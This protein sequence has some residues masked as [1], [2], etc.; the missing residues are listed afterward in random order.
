MS[1]RKRRSPVGA[2]RPSAGRTPRRPSAVDLSAA[3]GLTDLEVLRRGVGLLP[4]AGDPDPGYA[5]IVLG[6]DGERSHVRGCTCKVSRQRTC[7]H[8]L[9]LG[10][11]LREA[12]RRWGSLDWEAAFAGTL[13]ARLAQLLF[14]GE[15]GRRITV[16]VRPRA[17]GGFEVRGRGG[18]ARILVLDG[19]PAGLRLVDRLT[20]IGDEPGR[21]ALLE[22]LT[23][24]QITPYERHLLN[25]GMP[26]QRQAQEASLARRLACHAAREHGNPGGTFHPVVDLETGELQ[27]TFRT[28]DGTDRYRFAVPRPEVR[29]AF[30]LL[31]A[32]FPG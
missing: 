24:L 5:A 2:A 25:A 21:A 32:A 19:S 7:R 4:P 6:E 26:T 10:E 11:R 12:E 3:D 8:L 20:R 31:A 13:W 29:T 27:L 28:P 1:K 14:T 22:R 17:G 23:L 30:E 16:E 9:L 18:E 15:R